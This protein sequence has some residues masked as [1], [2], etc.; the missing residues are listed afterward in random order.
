MLIIYKGSENVHIK[1]SFLPH[2][3]VLEMNEFALLQHKIAGR[4][5]D[6]PVSPAASE[7]IVSMDSYRH[8]RCGI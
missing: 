4:P 1:K 3:K 7:R 6:V 2:T 5:D 8:Q